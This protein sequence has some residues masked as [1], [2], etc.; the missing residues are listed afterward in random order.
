M[1]LLCYSLAVY[2]LLVIEPAPLVEEEEE[3]EGISTN[4]P[5]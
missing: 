5:T 2:V 1:C 3:E 4:D